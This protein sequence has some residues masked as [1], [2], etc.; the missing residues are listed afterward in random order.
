[1]VKTRIIGIDFGTTYSAVVYHTEIQET[2]SGVKIEEDLHTK[3]IHV[4]TEDLKCV[5]RYKKVPCMS[6][7][8]ICEVPTT[9]WY[10]EDRIFWGYVV[11]TMLQSC[12]PGPGIRLD[13]FKLLLDRSDRISSIQKPIEEKLNELNKTPEGVI[14][15]FLTLLLSHAK[16]YLK[17]RDDL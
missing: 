13:K 2:A 5:E 1:M 17:D 14:T 12:A 15:E 4:Q 6:K 8:I 10:S 11:N 3:Y 9:L 7:Q 16:E